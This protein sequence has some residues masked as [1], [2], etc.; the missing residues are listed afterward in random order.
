MGVRPLVPR[1]DTDQARSAHHIGPLNGHRAKISQHR[2][3][4]IGIQTATASRAQQPPGNPVD[5]TQRLPGP[6]GSSVA[7]LRRVRRGLGRVRGPMHRRRSKPCWP[8]LRH[9][10][11][12]RGVGRALL[13]RAWRTADR[14]F[15]NAL[16]IDQLFPV[17]ALFDFAT[18][19]CSCSPSTNTTSRSTCSHRRD[20]NTVPRDPRCR[21]APH[22]SGWLLAV[23]QPDRCVEV[24]CGAQSLRCS[25]GQGNAG[26]ASLSMLRT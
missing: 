2:N 12:A 8:T 3:R 25:F 23:Y 9:R 26:P 4:D 13:S 10:A 17:A 11:R 15:L 1:L 16:Q 19:T 18:R 14:L 20:T 5:E 22:A 21:E 24:C 7:R 6:E